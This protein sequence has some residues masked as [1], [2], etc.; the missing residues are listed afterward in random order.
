MFLLRLVFGL[1][2]LVLAAIPAGLVALA[3]T[4]PQDQA[5]VAQAAEPTPAAVNRARALLRRHDPRRQVPGNPGRLRLAQ[6]ELDLALA[7]LPQALPGL[8]ARVKLEGATAL[9]QATWPL[10]ANPLGPY[11]N[12]SAEFVNTSAGLAPRHLRLGP[13]AVPD[14]L[15]GWLAALAWGQLREHREWGPVARSVEG[16]RLENGILTVTYRVPE[17][18]PQQLRSIALGPAE[19]A[20]LAAY[21]AVLA[22]TLGAG[23]EPLPLPRLLAPLFQLAEARGGG[24]D[25]YRAALLV[26]GVPLAEKSLATLVP[27]ARSWAPLPRR[28]VT[29]AGRRDSAQHFAASALLAAHAGTPLARVI[30]LWKELEDSRGGSGFSFADL[31]ADAAG[32]RL[33]EELAT[34]RPAVARRLAAGAAESDLLPS[35]AGLPEKLDA[36]AFRARYG[37]PGDPR[38]AALAADIEAQ[39]ADLP[40]YR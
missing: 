31:A 2:G 36:A 15:A 9:A 39:V 40:I 18:L 17:A 27:E 38:Y 37:A 26:A 1:I 7:A 3:L 23:R 14:A 24:A 4:L 28:A 35:L 6:G 32:T 13:L 16:A 12:L 20:T 21:H 29:L 25:E 5:L 10:P 22:Q 34:G 33:G 11:L 30:G 19:A 8:R